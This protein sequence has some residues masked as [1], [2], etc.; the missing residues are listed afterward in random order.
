LRL[1]EG[2]IKALG[3]RQVRSAGGHA[4]MAHGNSKLCV[5]RCKIGG[6]GSRVDAQALVGMT[7]VDQAE[8]ALAG[9][10]VELCLTGALVVLHAATVGLEDS[11][12]DRCKVGA[13]LADSAQLGLVDSRSPLYSGSLI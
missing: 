11:V 2:T 3:I 4:V 8:C 10:T 13:H 7:C 12:I 5:E 9:C 1:S 6:T